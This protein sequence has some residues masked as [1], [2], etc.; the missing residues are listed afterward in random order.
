LPEGA[1]TPKAYHCIW[2]A[3]FAQFYERGRLNRYRVK[4]SIVGSTP[5]LSAIYYCIF[6][7][8]LITRR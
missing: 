3:I 7:I 4:S 2:R 5:P 1:G 8:S 6:L